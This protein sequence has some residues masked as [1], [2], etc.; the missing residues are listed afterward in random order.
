MAADPAENQYGI[1]WHDSAWIPILNPENVLEYFSQRTNPF[2]DRTCN[3]EMIKMQRLD[4]SQLEMMQG[5]EY[6]V[7][8]VQNPILFIIRKQ[9]RHSPNQ[10]TPLADYYILAGVVYQCPDLGSLINSRML[11]ALHNLTSA[12]DEAFSYARYHPSKGYWWE[13]KEGDNKV[14]QD[15]AKKNKKEKS[16]SAPSSL[17][18]RQHVDLLLEELIKKF[19]PQRVKFSV[20]STDSTEPEGAKETVSKVDASS[21]RSSQDVEQN[22]VK[23]PPPAELSD[24]PPPSKKRK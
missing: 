20:T 2:Y 4:L 14:A 6:I 10:V 9:H 12:F 18:Q 23:R 17:F 5:L 19:P 3:N 24:K 15:D 13:F 1:S 16:K 21:S 22:Q 8:H 7:L 11:S